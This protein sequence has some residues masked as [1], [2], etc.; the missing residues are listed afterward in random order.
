MSAG[1]KRRGALAVDQ[2]A[3]P[4]DGAVGMKRSRNDCDSDDTAKQY[5]KFMLLETR[6][7]PSNAEP[8][9]VIS[10]K[11]SPAFNLLRSNRLSQTFHEIR[12]KARRKRPNVDFACRERASPQTSSE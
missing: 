8:L 7:M 4:V 2:S 11:R 12:R 5:V 1:Y 10:M 3:A 9:I 6:I